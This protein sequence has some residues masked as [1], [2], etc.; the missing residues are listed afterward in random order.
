MIL[1]LPKHSTNVIQNMLVSKT[2]SHTNYSREI[3]LCTIVKIG[4]YFFQ[5]TN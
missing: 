5:R 3:F 2:L 4:R 1:P